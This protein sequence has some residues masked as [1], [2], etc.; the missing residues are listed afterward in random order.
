MPKRRASDASSDS[1]SVVSTPSKVRVIIA[2]GSD[3]AQRQT[4]LVVPVPPSATVNELQQEALRRA[5]SLGAEIPETEYVLRLEAENGPVAF[6]EDR[7]KDVIDI[8]QKQNTFYVATTKAV[9]VRN[10]DELIYV[11]WITPALA[12]EHPSLSLIPTDKDGI[13]KSLTLSM[14]EQLA[15]KRVFPQQFF[16]TRVRLRIFLTSHE[17]PPE[18]FN[19]TTL[20]EYGC[21]GS[22]EEPL[23]LFLVPVSQN[24]E[25]GK[26]H[27]LWSFRASDRAVAAFQTCLTMLVAK[28]HQKPKTL[29]RLLKV[30]FNLTH[31]PP[32]IEA[33]QI[34]GT[35][36]KLQAGPTAVLASCFQE[37]ALKMVPGELVRHS[38]ASALEGSR[39]IFA[40]LFSLYRRSRNEPD[41]PA[42]ALA[43]R[44]QFQDLN[45]AADVRFSHPGDRRE[46]VEI[47]VPDNT[48]CS[49]SAQPD[50]R[51]EDD[52]ET[53]SIVGSTASG[54][55][56]LSDVE[57][58]SDLNAP[59]DTESFSVADPWE[60]NETI[61]SLNS[62]EGS[63]TETIEP[64]TPAALSNKVAPRQIMVC[65]DSACQEDLTI[66]ARAYWGRYDPI[67]NFYVEL[68]NGIDRPFEQRHYCLLSNDDFSQLMLEANNCKYFQ[69]FAPQELKAKTSVVIT[70][71]KEGF[72]SQYHMRSIPCANA[73]YCI[74][75]AITGRQITNED[76]GPAVLAAL[77]PIITQRK[78]NGTWDL[79]DWSLAREV[80]VT[81][82][83]PEEF[84][85]VC[86]DLSGS[87]GKTLGD[88]WAGGE[89]KNTFTRLD[90][91]KQV[92]RNIIA[93]MGAC[94]AHI[95]LVTFSSKQKIRMS[96]PITKPDVTF[97]DSLEASTCGGNTAI[98]DALLLAK[99][100]LL[101]YQARHP[102]TKLRIIALT[103]GQDNNSKAR[104]REVCQSLYDSNI[105]LDSIV[106]GTDVTD[107]LFIISKHTGGYAFRPTSR[108][109]L[110]QIFLLEP[111]LNISARPD[112][113]R[114]PF[115]NYDESTPKDADMPTVFDIPPC[116][117]HP[118]QHGSFISLN[119][120]SRFFTLR[121]TSL[122]GNASVPFL[123][124]Q[125]PVRGGPNVAA[126]L[127]SQI[128]AP[129]IRLPGLYRSERSG[130]S[131][132]KLYLD[133]MRL[134]VANPCQFMDV[135]VNESDMSFWKVVMAGPAESPY[136]NGTYVLF[137]H[138]TTGFPRT[139]PDVRLLTPILHP[140]I[141]K[142]GRICHGILA[143]GWDPNFHIHDIL[144]DIYGL[145]ATPEM[146][147]ALDE[148][149]ALRFKTDAAAAQA[150]IARYV[151][152]FAKKSRAEWKRE[153]LRI[154]GARIWD[155]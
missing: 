8:N 135:Y 83:S 51:A 137:V 46:V 152:K 66:L 44:I 103:D 33:L 45:G 139:P 113:E 142:H 70:M 97:K 117:P 107:D 122:L 52:S 134:M 102:D 65:A 41:I 86:F 150:E 42:A 68:R 144:Q 61:L 50:A 11:R 127:P 72:V 56:G 31:F 129:S 124:G 111:F 24:S 128:N 54:C 67:T 90:E 100:L 36:N 93:R 63:V 154:G 40:W 95:G 58:F 32:A 62:T 81:N 96:A 119:D 79:D 138:L 37:L 104:P 64:Q 140:N 49:V 77:Q 80:N 71:S 136:E 82:E 27:T 114:I 118:L 151:D 19:T 115:I 25:P 106:I 126:D 74:E 47:A 85:V 147:D 48:A 69:M 120:A 57:V 4:R 23:N 130:V 38:Q 105:V 6:R 28:A 53:M 87:M 112:I 101:P 14:V 2:F 17:L 7:L 16:T 26:L 133:E 43:Q 141:T 30:L 94:K 89:T 121:T 110:F 143:N 98:W 108:E 13:S 5:S 73:E 153:I 15:Y 123:S 9:S 149:A 18:L 34:L 55:A 22:I 29:R 116:R 60:N 131:F 148:L 145:L 12:L 75:N 3:I 39:Q 20:D 99:G 91:A 155:A 59:S 78:S 109:L 35:E 76:P 21:T 88:N 146:S 1:W 10:E 92:F 84:I 132:G 125:L